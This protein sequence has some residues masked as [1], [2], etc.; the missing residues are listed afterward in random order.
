MTETKRFTAS[1]RCDQ[2][3][4]SGEVRH[5]NVHHL[6]DR[7]FIE[8]VAKVGRGDS[9]DQVGYCE[10]LWLVD[11][12][13]IHLGVVRRLISI[14]ASIGDLDCSA[15]WRHIQ[16]LGREE[17][18]HVVCNDRRPILLEFIKFEQ[19]FDDTPVF[20]FCILVWF[21]LKIITPENGVSAIIPS[22]RDTWQYVQLTRP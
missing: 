19:L 6:D 14:L 15:R 2:R 8:S 18:F 20:A 12:N 7:S 21:D 16:L 9:V 17:V 13:L 10:H 11:A 22:V 3:V 5:P 1:W 4:R